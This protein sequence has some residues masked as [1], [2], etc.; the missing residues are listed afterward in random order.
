MTKILV[1]DDDKEMG[2]LLQTLF[3]LEGYQVVTVRAY[4]EIVPSL[5]E[6]VPDVVFMDVHVQDQDTIPLLASLRK[7]AEFARVPVVMASGLD[8][9]D[10][11][12]QAGANQFLVKPF[13]PND[14][15]RVVSEMLRA[16]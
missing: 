8:C 12:E 7:E 2:R 10:A 9:R 15:I 4:E 6:H 5:R 13:L 1:V 3:E 16:S 11:C 14:L